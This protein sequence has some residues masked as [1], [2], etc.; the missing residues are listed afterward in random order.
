MS[1]NSHYYVPVV[2]DNDRVAG[3]AMAILCYDLVGECNNFILVEN[4]V[5]D[6]EYQRKG[7]GKLLMKSIE[8]FGQRNECKYIILVSEMEREG[9]HRFYE[10]LGY[11]T[12]QQGFKK[13][14]M[15]G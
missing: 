5:V 2:C 15:H 6:P 1:N 7:F 14:I 9:S 11:T 3:T 8:K 10:S 12:D 13:R 4:V